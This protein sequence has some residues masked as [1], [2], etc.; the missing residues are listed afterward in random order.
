VAIVASC[1]GEGVLFAHW[2][3]AHRAQ[4]EEA[5]PV[6]V[7]SISWLAADIAPVGHIASGALQ[8][9][10]IDATVWVIVATWARLTHCD[11]TGALSAAIAAA[12][13]QTWELAINSSGD[14]LKWAASPSSGTRRVAIAPDGFPVHQGGLFRGSLQSDLFGEA[15]H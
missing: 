2:C 3:E 1:E 7:A 15:E 6:R 5:L 8:A 13:V 10:P 12:G 14:N 4:I 11:V 9:M